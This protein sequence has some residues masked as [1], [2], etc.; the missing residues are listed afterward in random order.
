[1]KHIKDSYNPSDIYQP[2]WDTKKRI[3]IVKRAI[4]HAKQE[5]DHQ[6][7]LN[8]AEAH[9]PLEPKLWD[10]VKESGVW[11]AIGII[12]GFWLH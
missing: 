10:K 4:K 8:M 12:I 3:A 9:E 6:R 11:I 5:N 1:M 2:S 7:L